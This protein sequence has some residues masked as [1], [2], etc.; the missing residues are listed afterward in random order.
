MQ[1]EDNDQLVQHLNANIDNYNYRKWAWL[2]SVVYRHFSRTQI[3]I[4]KNKFIEMEI[5]SIISEI[6]I[7]SLLGQF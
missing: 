3:S 1:F 5:F 4:K 7:F 6:E 2:V